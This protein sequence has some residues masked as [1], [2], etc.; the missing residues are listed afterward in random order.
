MQRYFVAKLASGGWMKLKK[1]RRVTGSN[2]TINHVTEKSLVL[3]FIPDHVRGPAIFFC[4]SDFF[5]PNCDVYCPSL[6][7][8]QSGIASAIPFLPF[9]PGR[10][11]TLCGQPKIHNAP[12]QITVVGTIYPVL[13]ALDHIVHIGL[14]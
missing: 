5:G 2:D 11:A 7:G 3:D 10:D 12:S 6:S 9:T 14:A 1:N 4:E 8:S 13:Q